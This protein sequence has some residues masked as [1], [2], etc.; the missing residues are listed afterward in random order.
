MDNMFRKCISRRDFM[1]GAITALTLSAI[2]R[3]E[4]RTDKRPNIIVF[5]TDDQDKHSIG[6]YGGN[7]MTPNLD[8]MA[9][10]G[11]VFHQ[12]YVS[13]TVCTPSRYSF[14]TGRY[15]GRSYCKRY[16]DECP[17]GQQG[18]PSFNVE[19][20]EDNMNVGAILQK[21]G[22]ATGYV[23]KFH[24][25]PDIKRSE[26]YERFGLKYVSNDEP[27]NYETTVAFRHNERCYRGYLNKKGFSWA[28]NIYWGNM[29][30]PFNHHNPEWT[31]DAALEFI[32]E[33]K[34][35]PFYLHY[36]TTLTHGP[37]KSWRNSMDHPFVS[38][39][40]MLNE[41]PNVMTDRKALLKRL[42]DKGLDP[43][44]GHAGYAQVDDS[45][46]AILKKL[47]EL[48]IADNTL[49]VFTSDHGSNMKGSLYNI[50]GIC[51]P[52]IMR[53]PR[54]IKAGF[55][56]NELVQNIDLAPT[57]FDLAGANVPDKYVMDG[58]SLKPLFAG[59]KPEPWRDHLYFEVGSGRAVCTKDWKYIAVRYP[60]EQISQIKKARPESLPKLMAYI[61]RMG[62][63]TRGAQN[64]GFFDYDQ[65]YNVKQDVK[66]QRNLAGNP[67]YR[68]RL[69]KMRGILKKDL[70]SFGRPFGEFVPGGNA[71]P[72]GLIDKQVELV[73][74]IKIVGKKV[75]LPD[76][77]VT[78][79]QSQL[80][81]QQKAAE[82]ENRRAGKKRRNQTK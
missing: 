45:I 25:G 61:G 41:I 77:R 37:D 34:D 4:H 14:L 28:K 60:K 43:E 71:A 2:V 56:C 16:E 13:S 52:W 31:I 74:K 12:A 49:I 76:G 55:E 65:L 53:W 33:H 57:F 40:G 39:E 29:Q 68:E 36:C 7:S 32:D 42:K 73:K 47:D 79:E 58:R 23:G 22:Y 78:D 54:A 27:A 35:R 70:E 24:V 48:D 50:D 46:G 66:E 21:S 44:Q 26:E 69:E 62:I 15:A 17:P 51:V 67:D 1:R 64:P 9:R 11:M 18:F 72:S 82:R 10:E 38:G 8:R 19:L 75:I 20:E 30:S 81:R 59:G 63:G 5:I 80:E 3:S 6:A